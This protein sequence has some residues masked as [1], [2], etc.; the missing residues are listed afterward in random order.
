MSSAGPSPTALRARGLAGFRAVFAREFAAAFDA[1]IAYVAIGATL[2][3]TTSWFLNEFF[4]TGKLD[5]APFLALLPWALAVLAPALGMRLWSED[6]RTRTFELWRTLPLSASQVVLGK[7][8]A[9]LA[10]LVLFLFGSLP[11][12]ALL[13][14]LGDPDRGA[15]AAGYL[16]ALLLG[17]EFLAIAA[18]VSSRTADQITAFLLSAL[19]ATVL[20]GLGDPRVVA[21]VDGL[22][23]ALAPGTFLA[24]TFSPAAWF[25]EFVR[26]HVPLAGIVHMAGVAAVFLFLNARSVVE[27]RS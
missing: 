19:A 15:I 22:A 20:L 2:V 8:A 16:G 12:V 17:A 4:L 24:A 7:Y 13:E 23:P 14:W 21:I 18:F 11:L 1:P 26:G 25:A 6:Y 9:A 5:L 10:V 3:A 27:E